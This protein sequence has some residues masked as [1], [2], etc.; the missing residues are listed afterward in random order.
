MP[1]SPAADAIGV[2]VDANIT[3]TFDEAMDGTTIIPANF[4]LMLGASSVPGSIS[5][6]DKTATFNPDTNL[7][8]GSLYSATLTTAT[9]DTS[10]NGLASKKM[11]NFTT[12]P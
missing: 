3:A 7:A 2:A 12:A 6:L 1:T 5:Y 11:W 9:M 8:A 10:F 4:T